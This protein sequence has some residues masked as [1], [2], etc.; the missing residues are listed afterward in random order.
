[1][2]VNLLPLEEVAHYANYSQRKDHTE[3]ESETYGI[4]KAKHLVLYSTLKRR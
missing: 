2:A 4:A 1:L 3:K